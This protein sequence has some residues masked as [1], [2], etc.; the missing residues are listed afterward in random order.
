MLTPELWRLILELWA[1]L[2]CAEAH[3]KAGEIQLGGV[4]NHS[5]VIEAHPG[6]IGI[7]LESKSSS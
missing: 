7:N 3:H 5:G 4:V 2:G 1:H 6:I